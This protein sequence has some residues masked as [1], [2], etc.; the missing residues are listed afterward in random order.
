MDAMKKLREKKGMS[1][2]HPLEKKAK[3][4][5]LDDLSK[6]ADD[7]MGDK[8]K[9][10]NKLTVAADSPKGLEEGMSHAHDLLKHLPEALDDSHHDHENFAHSENEED[11]NDGMDAYPDADDGHELE[12]NPAKQHRRDEMEE[13]E[14]QH[15][16]MGGEVAIDDGDADDEAE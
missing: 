6:M 15:L 13:G 1:K 3:M 12:A 7:A 14:A 11:G 10:M 16:A 5:V 8:L 2:M 9:G 4:G